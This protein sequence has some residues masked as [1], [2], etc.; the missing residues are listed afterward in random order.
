[1]EEEKKISTLDVRDMALKWLTKGEVY[2]VLRIT[3]TMYLPP[4]EQV[5]SDFI[6]DLLRGD[7][8]VRY[9]LIYA[10]CSW[11]QS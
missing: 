11:K 9:I 8:L 4:V 5:N 2:K 10:V 3:S 7:K 1:M 6:R